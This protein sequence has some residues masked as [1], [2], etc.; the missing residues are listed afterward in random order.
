MAYSDSSSTLTFHSAVY[1]SYDGP[2]NASLVDSTG[3]WRECPSKLLQRF[4]FTVPRVSKS[5]LRRV[6]YQ[7]DKYVAPFALKF[8]DALLQYATAVMRRVFSEGNKPEGSPRVA[9][10]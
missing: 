10:L 8:T 4:R 1:I 3:E 7:V 2:A 5:A 9:C 6:H